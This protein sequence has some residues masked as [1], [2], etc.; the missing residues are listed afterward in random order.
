MIGAR[1]LKSLDLMRELPLNGL[2]QFCYVISRNGEPLLIED[3][4][5]F[6]IATTI[7]VEFVDT[8][9]TKVGP[10]VLTLRLNR[11]AADLCQTSHWSVGPFNYVAL[12]S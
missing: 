6:P 12:L 11:Y 1:A 8:R 7:D 9:H 2:P 3:S 5:R 4:Q 10:D